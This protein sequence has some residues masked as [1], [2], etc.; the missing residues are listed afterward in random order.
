RTYNI[1]EINAKLDSLGLRGQLTATGPFAVQQSRKS[2]HLNPSE[3]QVQAT[4]VDPTTSSRLNPDEEQVQASHVDPTTST[5][6]EDCHNCALKALLDARSSFLDFDGEG[7]VAAFCDVVNEMTEE[8][9]VARVEWHKHISE[10]ISEDDGPRLQIPEPPLHLKH[11][12]GFVVKSGTRPGISTSVDCITSN[13]TS[14]YIDQALS[15][16]ICTPETPSGCVVQDHPSSVS[17]TSPPTPS[18]TVHDIPIDADV[19]TVPEREET[20]PTRSSIVVEAYRSIII[21]PI[22]FSSGDT[23]G[24]YD[25]HYIQELMMFLHKEVDGLPKRPTEWLTTIYLWAD[26]ESMWAILDLDP[27]A[28]PV[29]GRPAGFS[30]WNKAGRFRPASLRPPKTA[31]LENLRDVWWKWW[32]AMNPEWRPREGLWLLPGDDGDGPT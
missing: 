28:A 5:S 6:A 13:P 16:S 22:A 18:L 7:A 11:G 4:H 24:D 9:S 26:L 27:K 15:P 30:T 19:V 3:E 14:E 8:G 12:D 23:P 31:S 2:S 21:P 1:K 29:D 25:H 32:S 10:L 17:T 20:A